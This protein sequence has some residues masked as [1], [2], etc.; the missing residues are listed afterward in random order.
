MCVCVCMGVCGHAQCILFLKEI[1]YSLLKPS[2]IK[3][4]WSTV[5]AYPSLMCFFNRVILTG[6][7][8]WIDSRKGLFIF[9]FF[10]FI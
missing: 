2:G 1:L 4:E 3:P 6:L 8:V 7:T 10:F 5:P 9:F